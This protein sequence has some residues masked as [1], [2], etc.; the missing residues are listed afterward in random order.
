MGVSK[1]GEVITW[2]QSGQGAVVGGRSRGI[3][4]LP[5]QW[6]HLNSRLSLGMTEFSIG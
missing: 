2:P 5:L 6:M 4:I 3:R 1:A